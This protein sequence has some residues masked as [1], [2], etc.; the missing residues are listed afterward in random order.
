MH[1]S[2]FEMMRGDHVKCGSYVRAYCDLAR[3]HGMPMWLANGVFQEGWLRWHEGDRDA[4]TAQMHEG[5]GLL[6]GQAQ[7]VFVP[8]YRVVLAETEAKAG[9]TEAALATVAVALASMTKTGEC[10]F[11][12]EAHRVRGE[13]VLKAAP[14]DREAAEAAF[15]QAIEVA[16]GNATKR[17]EFR[18]ALRLAQMW[19]DHGRFVEHE[20]LLAALGG[21]RADDSDTKLL[22]TGDYC[23]M[24]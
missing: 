22:V 16:R 14:T 21:D 19:T 11:L 12:G 2:A 9:D 17:F 1:A 18:A 7:S 4:G 10:W 23:Q 20:G 8:F 13:I 3:E 5:L 15:V 6:H 24:L